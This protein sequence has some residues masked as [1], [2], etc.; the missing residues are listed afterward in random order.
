MDFNKLSGLSHSDFYNT[1]SNKYLDYSEEDSPKHMDT[2]GNLVDK[3]CI[4]NN[5]M[6]WNQ[7]IL[8]AVRRMT[9]EEFENKYKNNM[10]ELHSILKRCTDLN[11]Q[12][13]R[14]MDELDKKLI[15]GIKGTID[16]STLLSPQHKTY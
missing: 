2:I 5:K 8:Y 14:L 7:D 4:V 15:D 6:F 10:T 1:V 13:A 11:A 3:L 16:L 12:R 9:P